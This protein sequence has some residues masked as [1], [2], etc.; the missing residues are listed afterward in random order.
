MCLELELEDLK[1]GCGIELSDGAF[2]CLINDGYQQEHRQMPSTCVLSAWATLNFFT[3][4]S[5]ILRTNIPI[6]Q[7][8]IA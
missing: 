8:G 5:W 3:L 4:G 6:E 1:H 7:G 2:M